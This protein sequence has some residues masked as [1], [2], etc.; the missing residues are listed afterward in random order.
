MH[1]GLPCT[2]DTRMS[3]GSRHTAYGRDWNLEYIRDGNPSKFDQDIRHH[4]YST[5][6]PL[7]ITRS[8]LSKL[9][10]SYTDRRDSY[11]REDS[12]SDITPKPH[13]PITHKHHNGLQH[14]LPQARRRHPLGRGPTP[15]SQHRTL[16]THK[17]ECPRPAIPERTRHKRQKQVQG[18]L[19]GRHRKP[20]CEH[21]WGTLNA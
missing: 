14:L 20:G 11:Q 7:H 3:Q 21:R 18:S 4:T 12:A 8:H 10:P 19:H 15:Q 16:R 17:R 2:C 9:S 5:Q 13:E 6:L 1:L